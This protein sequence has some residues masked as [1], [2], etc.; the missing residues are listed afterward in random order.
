MPPT[1]FAFTG[2]MIKAL[3]LGGDILHRNIPTQ[4]LPY[5]IEII[6]FSFEDDENGFTDFLDKL[7]EG[8]ILLYDQLI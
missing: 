1:C 4:F 8:C 2:P 7:K 6:C 5:V 3:K